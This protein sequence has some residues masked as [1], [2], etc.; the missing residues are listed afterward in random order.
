MCLSAAIQLFVRK[1][2]EQCRE[3]SN[4]TISKF[5]FFGRIHVSY[6]WLGRRNIIQT[7]SRLSVKEVVE[8]AYQPLCAYHRL[9]S[10][11]KELL[12]LPGHHLKPPVSVPQ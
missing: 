12:A 4:R 2:G 6:S 10:Q 3:C 5:I 9:P 11:S 8:I 1:M 7:G